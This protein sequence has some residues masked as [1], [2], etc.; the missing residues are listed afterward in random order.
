MFA[1]KS[2]DVWSPNKSCLT[3]NWARFLMTCFRLVAIDGM[4]M[5]QC[6]HFQGNFLFQGNFDPQISIET[7][8]FPQRNKRDA[9]GCCIF[10]NALFNLYNFFAWDKDKV[11]CTLHFQSIEYLV[12]TAIEYYNLDTNKKTFDMLNF[13][14]TFHG[15]SKLQVAGQCRSVQVSAGQCRSVQ[16]SAGQCRLMQVNAG[17]CRLM[18]VS[19]ETSFISFI[20][21]QVS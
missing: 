9:R 12:W 15:R 18:Q 3:A 1:V 7:W 21:K 11:K 6:F 19:A 2:C 17:Q 4:Q 20:M 13:E 8:K 14:C 10:V 5:R 16:V